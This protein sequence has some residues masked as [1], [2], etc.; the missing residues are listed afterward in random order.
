MATTFKPLYATNATITITLTSLVNS[1]TLATG[2]RQ[3]AAVD[4]STNLYGDAM[5][6]GHCKSGGTPTA[7]N[8]YTLFGVWSN[9]NGTT[10]SNNASGS[11]A[12]YT[13]PDSDVNMMVLATSLCTAT[14][15]LVSYFPPVSFCQAAGLLFLPRNWGVVFK[16][17][18][19][20]TLSAT[21]SDHVFSYMG[22]NMQGV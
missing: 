2:Y 12:A 15:S 16:N 8:V 4:N 9:D 20:A 11:D 5:I 7:G 1:T 10:Y 18:S 19:G 14:A 21:G 6:Y 3:S 13:Q 22:V 17:G